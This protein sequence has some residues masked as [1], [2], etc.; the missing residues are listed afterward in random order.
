[1]LLF[2]AAAVFSLASPVA[3]AVSYDPSTTIIVLV[4][5]FDP[6]GYLRTGVFGTDETDSGVLDDVNTI[7]NTLGLP[8]WQTNPTAPNHVAGSSYYGDTAPAWYT[9]TDIAEDN[10]APAVLPRYALR[11]AKYIKHCLNRAPGATAVNVVAGSFGADVT[12][13]MIEHNL[14]NLCSDGKI[15]RWNTI[16]GV[17]RGNWAATNAPSWLASLFGIDS[18]DIDYMDYNW[19]SANVSA[20]TTMNSAYYGP[21]II[22]NFI[23]TDDTDGYLTALNNNAND[24]T[25]MVTDEYFAGYT[26]TAALHAATNGTLQMPGISYQHCEHSDIV[27]ETGMWAGLGA[28]SQNN[29]RVTIKVSRVKALSTGDSWIQ[30]NGE[31]VFGFTAAS[32]RAATL[33]G[34]TNPMTDI[35]YSDGVMPLISIAKNATKYPNT[36]VFDQIVPAGETQLNVSFLIEELDYHAQFYSIYENI[37]GDNKVLSSWNTSISTTTPGTVTLSSSY[38]QADLTTTITTVY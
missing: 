24:S 17:V 20:N 15:A 34:V 5:G 33:Y 2:A 7:A 25:N 27:D 18:P 14:C 8:T 9:S 26:T 13:Y 35:R 30:G 19:I 36:V 11:M 16:V 3:H 1:M 21:M 22:T 23:A 28:A 32:P 38:A 6:D 10:A 12:R 4:H 29:K 31:W 37:F